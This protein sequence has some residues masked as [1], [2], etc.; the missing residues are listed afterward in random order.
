MAIRVI[1]QS[2]SFKLDRRCGDS[3]LVI[4]SYDLSYW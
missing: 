4:V 2:D 1:L 3:F